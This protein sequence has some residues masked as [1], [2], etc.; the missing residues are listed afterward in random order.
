MEKIGDKIGVFGE[1]SVMGLILGVL[2]GIGAGFDVTSV[3]SLGMICAAT[4][5]LMPKV[6]S[7]LME[8][9]API[10]EATQEMVSKKMKGREIRIGMTQQSA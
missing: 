2:L 3:L 8:G 1:P 10:A 6:C 9:L 4:M 5:V 7:I